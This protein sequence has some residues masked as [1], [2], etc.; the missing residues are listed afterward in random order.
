MKVCAFVYLSNHCHLLLVPED[1]AQLASFMRYVNS[2]IAREVARL[3]GWKEKI[4]GRR[5]T[6]IVVSDEPLAQ[7]SR[8]RYLLAQGCK[9]GLVAS[10]RHWPGATCVKGLMTGD[11]VEGV[12]IDRTEQFKAYE[13]REPNPDTLFT[14]RCRLELSPLPCWADTPDH[15]WRA[16]VRRWVREVEDSARDKRV[17]GREAI[18][19]QDPHSKPSSEARR[20]P[21]PRFHTIEPTVR[22]ALEWSYHLARLA[23]RQAVEDLRQGRKAHFPAGCFPPATAFVPLQI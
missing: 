3:H 2:K 13:R 1:A 7:E 18:L 10:P 4:W 23:Y 6:D 19:R 15:R 20:S 11:E 8:L 12:W 17:L 21:A 5:Y 9:E 16:R 22:R 14:N